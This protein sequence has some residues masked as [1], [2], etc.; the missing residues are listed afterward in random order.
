MCPAQ[1]AEFG[2]VDVA[3]SG[4]VALVQQGLA[5]GASGVGEEP[6]LGFGGVPVG[7]EQVGAEVADGRRLLGGAQQFEHGEAVADGGAVG[8][9]RAPP[10]SGVR[11]RRRRARRSGVL[12]RQEP[13]MPRWEWRVRPPSTRMRMC[14]PRGATSRTVRP[15]RSA[16]ASWGTRKSRAGQ[17]LAGERLVELRALYQT[18]SPSG[19]G[20]SSQRC[21][22]GVIG[23][24]WRRALD[25]RYRRAEPEAAGGGVEA[26]ALQQGAERGGEGGVPVDPFHRDRA[27]GARLAARARASAAVASAGS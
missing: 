20:S 10:G 24:R 7:A 9:A 21:G 4:E 3:D 1:E 26:G 14:L 11:V 18:V 8:G 22:R 6:A 27:E 25:A 23:A 5:E 13:S 12:T 2:L 15:V 19:M 16:V 17:H